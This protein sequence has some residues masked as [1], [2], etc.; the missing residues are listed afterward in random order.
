MKSDLAKVLHCLEG[1]PL[2]HY[3]VDCALKAGLRRVVVVVGYQKERV[4]EALRDYPVEFALQLEQNGTGHAVQVALATIPE[5]EGSVVVLAGDAPFL[6]A[7]T[8]RAFVDRHASSG[9]DCTVLTAVVPDPCGYGRIVR[10][11][12]GNV[13]GIVEHDD[14][15]E[16]ERR[17]REVNSGMYCFRLSSL[18]SCAR[19]LTDDNA[20]GELY[21][22]DVVGIMRSKNMK[23]DTYTAPDWREIL[24]INTVEQLQQAGAILNDLREKI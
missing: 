15:V 16:T 19:L 5:R 13:A 23:L 18:L 17:I 24:G 6:R 2:V 11:S 10:D 21:L 1:R 8:L 7:S 3:V 4:M 9:A 20:Q 22:T 12:E 14:C